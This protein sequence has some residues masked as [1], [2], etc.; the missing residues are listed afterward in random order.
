MVSF[1]ESSFVIFIIYDLS[2]SFDFV[3]FFISRP[4]KL[5]LWSLGIV[6]ASVSGFGT[7]AP[8]NLS[9]L[10]MYYIT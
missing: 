6:F 4:L 1:S 9:V 8:S 7:F 3:I 2:S 5:R 10:A